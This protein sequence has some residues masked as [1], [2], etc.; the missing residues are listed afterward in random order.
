MATKAKINQAG[1]RLINKESQVSTEEANLI[2]QQFRSIH[3]HPMSLFR[4]MMERKLKKHSIKSTPVQRLKRIPS[5]I[6]KLKIQKKMKL[7]RMQDIGGLR[8]ILN[9]MQ[10]VDLVRDE[11]KKVEKHGSFKFTF[12]NEKNY[13]ENPPESGYRSIHMV[14]KYDKNIEIE[15]Q[16]RVE[17]QIRTKL[18]HSWATAVEV[19]GTYLNQPL[20]QSLG[21]SEYLNIF[22]DISKLFVTLEKRN[23]DIDYDF[24]KKV[25]Q[26]IASVEL[27]DKLQ[28]FNMLFRHLNDS[29]NVQ[30]Q[31]VLLKMNFKERVVEI[32]Q[33]GKVKFEQANK[34]YSKMELD[35]FANK[36]VEVVLLSI[37]DIKKLKQSYP[38]YFMDTT[39][40]INNLD[41]L[42]NFTKEMQE[43]Q[44]LIDNSKD[45]KHKELLS[46]MLDDIFKNTLKS[47]SR[48][49][50]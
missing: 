18:Q 47:F 10:E 43:L 12:A 3:Q 33:Y 46:K 1:Q 7:S 40:F 23:I 20:K 26:D 34:D 27:F 17:I 48:S 13:I 30:G 35:N 15:K 5:I 38:N 9:N 24:I 11:I 31:Y 32:A 37:Q 25:Q 39:E 49:K 29:N 21:K 28:S 44:Q 16:C 19:L 6:K 2:L 50:K 14:Y 22:K 4:H 41:K 8:I 42:F 36:A 45:E